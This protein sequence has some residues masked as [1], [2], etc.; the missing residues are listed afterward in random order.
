MARLCA[1]PADELKW[2]PDLLAL[3]FVFI[4][5][6]LVRLNELYR[7]LHIIVP[8]LVLLIVFESLKLTK[9]LVL[10]RDAAFFDLNGLNKYLLTH[11]VHNKAIV[12]LSVILHQ[13]VVTGSPCLKRI[14]QDVC[15]SLPDA[16][17][18]IAWRR[19]VFLLF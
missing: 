7:I 2:V 8:E 19:L 15:G 18:A 6:I 5:H 16:N 9:G 3:S 14:Q 12:A 13:R 4:A 17:F 1:F 10:V 11:F